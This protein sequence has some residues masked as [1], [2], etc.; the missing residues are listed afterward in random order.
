[1]VER[2]EE[3]PDQNYQTHEADDN[4]LNEL[5]NKGAKAV[6][7][8]IPPIET[9]DKLAK[10]KEELT[11]QINR[12]KKEADELQN[13]VKQIEIID[14]ETR[15]TTIWK[16][17]F[18]VEEEEF[19]KIIKEFNKKVLIENKK[20]KE[21]DQKIEETRKKA[22]KLGSKRLFKP[23][24]M[25]LLLLDTRTREA[26]WYIN[27]KPD[28][29]MINIEKDDKHVVI[30]KDKLFFMKVGEEKFF[31]YVA[32]TDNMVAYPIEPFFDT[33]IVYGTF[34]AFISNIKALRDLKTGNNMASWAKI[35]LYAGIGIAV[36][37]II[38]SVF[39]PTKVV[40]EGAAAIA[41]DTNAGTIS[42]AVA[43]GIPQ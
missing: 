21:I 2:T 6:G 26:I 41:A 19:K 20:V 18:R 1:M 33:N 32:D 16:R 4:I 28:M 42:G 5:M 7:N 38:K 23:E 35:L 36:V 34:V 31:L 40:A 39:F 12:L 25:M 37:V 24:G 15:K 43:G 13:T 9:K 11:E 3:I 10:K 14:P 17:L 27:V 22:E 8:M 29:N 30:S